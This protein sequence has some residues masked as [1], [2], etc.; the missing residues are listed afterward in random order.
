MQQIG[1]ERGMDDRETEHDRDEFGQR[2]EAPGAFGGGKNGTRPG[3]LTD[4]G[5]NPSDLPSGDSPLR[6][7]K[8]KPDDPENSRPT[9]P[10]TV[11]ENS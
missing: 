1:Q 10:Y 2:N 4:T 6:L 5:V 8:D 9:A 7:S 11:D 3:G